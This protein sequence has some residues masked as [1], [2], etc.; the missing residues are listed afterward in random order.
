MEH[1][2]Q[3]K[4]PDQDAQVATLCRTCG[5]RVYARYRVNQVLESVSMGYERKLMLRRRE[6]RR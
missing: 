3:N 2:R 4:V 1:V 5:K 6:I